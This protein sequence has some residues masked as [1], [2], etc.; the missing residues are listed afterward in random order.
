[1]KATPEF[2]KLRADITAGQT[3]AKT[4]S[5]AISQIHGQA[6][7][8][9]GRVETLQ[10]DVMSLQS[11]LG[12]L[13]T[14]TVTNAE[15]TTQK[16]LED[17]LQGLHA[18]FA[19]DIATAEQGVAGV[20]KTAE[21]VAGVGKAARKHLADA[22]AGAHQRVAAAKASAHQAVTSATDHAKHALDQALGSAR[23]KVTA[24][25]LK[26]KRIMASVRAK[27]HTALA[28]AK[29]KAMRGGQA[30][31]AAAQASADKAVADAQKA[32]TT[33]NNDYADL[34]GINQQAV[35]WELP[36]GDATDVTEQEGSLIYTITGT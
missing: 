20:G 35:A 2:R 28:A 19:A 14:A 16:R 25:V 32:L 30:A 34:L 5:D 21:G 11:K 3:L 36:A 24:A 6:Q 17:S 27:A 7:S 31:V 15:N 22:Q 10:T 26:V 33:A 4:V 23:Q 9:V 13:L 8:V 18:R 29:A 12:T 1:V